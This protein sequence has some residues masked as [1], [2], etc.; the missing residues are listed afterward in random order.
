LKIKR[1]KSKELVGTIIIIQSS[2]ARGYNNALI[3]KSSTQEEKGIEIVFVFFQL[4]PT[5]AAVVVM[6]YI[7]YFTRL[8][9][10]MDRVVGFEPM[11]LHIILF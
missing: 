10:E 11:T 4:G 1:I 7:P 2:I 3:I 9:K 6:K 5:F 8:I